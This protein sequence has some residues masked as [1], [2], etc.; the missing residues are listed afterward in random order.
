MANSWHFSEAHMI[1]ES[2]LTIKTDGGYTSKALSRPV[3]NMLLS[4]SETGPICCLGQIAGIA[5]VPSFRTPPG[6]GCQL[7]SV[8]CLALLHTHI[9]LWGKR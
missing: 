5:H 6:E 4:G 7:C 3:E 1:R 2:L 9:H 8:H